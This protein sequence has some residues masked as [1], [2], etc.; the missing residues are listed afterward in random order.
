MRNYKNYSVW[1]KSHKLTLDVYKILGN[2]SQEELYSLVS[3]MKRSSS[4]I[5]T[6]IAEGCGRKSDKDF[7]RFLYIA[8]G[9]ANELE[10]QILLSVDLNFITEAQGKPLIF[11]VEEIKKM[12]NSLIQKLN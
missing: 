8:F 5:P 1:E 6:N 2:Y 7:S 4:S 3:Q 12:L 9:S 11:Q 10:Y